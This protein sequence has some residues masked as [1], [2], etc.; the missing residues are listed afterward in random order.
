MKGVQQQA[1]QAT[2]G[3]A[4]RRRRGLH[5]PVTIQGMTSKEL[6]KMA[7]VARYT[8]NKHA[9]RRGELSL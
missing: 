1:D 4:C 5:S 6:A 9:C 2:A 3:A 7:T 8:M